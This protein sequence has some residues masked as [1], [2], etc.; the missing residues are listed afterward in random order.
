MIQVENIEFLN[1]EAV[2]FSNSSLEAILVPAWGSNLISL[3]WKS[4]NVNVFNV[5]ETADE[6]L[7]APFFYGVPILFPP[8]RIDRGKMSY[9]GQNYQFEIN[10]TEKENHLHGFLHDK[11]FQL[12]SAEEEGGKA[13]VKTELVSSDFPEIIDVFPHRF[14]IVMIYTLT[15]SSI[16]VE[17]EVKNLSD[18]P[19]PVGLGYHTAF[20]FPLN[21]EGNKEACTFTLPVS[22]QW[23][24]NER[25]LP[26]GELKE[27]GHNYKE[28][29]DP[30][31]KELDDI[32][33]ADIDQNGTSIATLTDR[34]ANVKVE[35]QCDREF[36][37]WVAF[38]GAEG[39]LCLEPY[40]WV[41]NA[42][43]V[44]QPV[45]LTGFKGIEPGQSISSTTT[46]S[47]SG[48]SD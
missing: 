33:L 13:V 14:H 42:P 39:L 4:G 47:V 25:S 41:T 38:N 9:A 43:N 10:E 31:G 17:A 11:P 46:F 44:N 18:R 29:T 23:Q 19:M 15:G 28:E 35:Y 22:K 27:S 16:R 45:D 36:K 7:S 30:A 48:L 8:N 40:T 12:I 21:K 37:H 20:P 6:Y 5:P 32:F 3:K 34:T 1:E 2:K 24:L 26:T